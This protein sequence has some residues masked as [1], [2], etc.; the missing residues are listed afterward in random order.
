MMLRGTDFFPFLDYVN[1]ILDKCRGGSRDS[2]TSM[3][4]R[5]ILDVAAALALNQQ[6]WYVPEIELMKRH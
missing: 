5:I 1:S 6:M 3:M 2:A 4:E